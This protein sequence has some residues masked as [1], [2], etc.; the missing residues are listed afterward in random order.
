MREKKPVKKGSSAS[1]I[2][3]KAPKKSGAKVSLAKGN[4]KKPQQS[5]ES[6]GIKKQYL[7]SHNFCNVTFRLPK[8]AA[9]DAQIITIVGDFNEWNL[10]ETPLKKL[11]TGEFKVTMKLP[12]GKEYR[13]RYFIDSNRWEN[14]WEADKYLPNSFGCDDSVVVI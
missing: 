2:E 11:K 3:K 10:T 5:N 4:G 9:P 12:K 6:S 13:F 7:K 1:K 14:D 8:E